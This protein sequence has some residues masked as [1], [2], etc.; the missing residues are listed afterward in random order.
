MGWQF[1]VVSAGLPLVSTGWVG[2][3]A[4]LISHIFGASAGPTDL[5]EPY[6]HSICSRLFGVCFHSDG[7]VPTERTEAYRA[8]RGLDLGRS[9]T[10]YSTLFSK[11][12]R[13]ARQREGWGKR[14]IPW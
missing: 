11:A 5:T 14:F 8:S 6:G 10:S 7:K 3:F 12:S 13:K 1:R 2:G 9:I 4:Q